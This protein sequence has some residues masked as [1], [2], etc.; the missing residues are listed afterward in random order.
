M[1]SVRLVIRDPDGT[2]N[3][4]PAKATV[5]FAFNAEVDK[6][7]NP[8]YSQVAWNSFGYL[9]Q[10]GDNAPL[11]AA[12]QSVGVKMPGVPTLTKKLVN[13]G[14]TSYNAKRNENFT[15][16]IY[17]GAD[18]K[19][20]TSLSAQELL[21]QL[22][23]DNVTAT[24]VT[25]TVPEGESASET[26]SLSS[27]RPYN[28]Y[29]GHTWVQ[30]TDEWKWV[31]GQQYTVLELPQSGNSDYIFRT[32]NGVRK[33][34]LTFLYSGASP[35]EIT[36]INERSSWTLRVAKKSSDDG[37]ALPGAKFALYTKNKALAPADD[38]EIPNSDGVKRSLKLD[39]VTWYLTN[40]SITDESGLIT[41]NELV[42]DEEY[43]LEIEA[44]E[45]YM[46]NS[47]PGQIVSAEKSSGL[48]EITVT[49]DPDPTKPGRSGTYLTVKKVWKDSGHE[50]SRPT[51]V[52]MALLKNG[53]E[54]GRVQLDESNG[55]EYTWT[56]LDSSATWTAKE[57]NVP[58]HYTAS[59]TMSG[60][61]V[62][63]TNTR[64]TSTRTTKSDDPKKE[65]P[66][67][68]DTSLPQTGMNWWPVMILFGAGAACF[69]SGVILKNRRKKNR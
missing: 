2:K 56:N 63:I 25:L 7:S 69:T 10:V 12:P 55:W 58:D 13:S 37:T 52:T 23:K 42:A 18:R 67:T 68:P 26:I 57:I 41:W 59:T 62:T 5:E 29:R 53:T 38:T 47:E 30:G 36:A 1:R 4:I 27:L 6:D 17:E 60:R 54:S 11:R 43:L 14:G 35:L 61:T 15:F 40:V 28:T 3:L 66:E 32:I 24:L 48:R 20:D 22:N 19:L 33:N 44:P 34:P 51:S 64:T 8:A 31:N 45:G 65:T 49:N 16:L 50:N 9:Y 21:D 46:L 39:G